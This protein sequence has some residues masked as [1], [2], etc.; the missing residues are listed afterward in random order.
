MSLLTHRTALLQLDRQRQADSKR[1]HLAREADLE[2][3]E[4]DA[5]LRRGVN[6]KG[7]GAEIAHNIYC[8]V[9]LTTH[10]TF[11]IHNPI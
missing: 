3:E 2:K 6:E 1:A 4:Y 7:R 10:S 11:L 5:V 9:Y 8:R